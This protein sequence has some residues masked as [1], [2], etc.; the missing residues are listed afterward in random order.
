VSHTEQR[1]KMRALL[2]TEKCVPPASVHDPL[3]AALAE[4]VGFEIGLLSGS[5]VSATTLAAPDLC[6]QTITEYAD[7]IRRIMRTSN[8]CLLVDADNGY[9]N[10][11]NAM[12]MVQEFEH[13]GVTA[14][15]VEDSILPVAFG[16]PDAAERL[17][18][19]AEGVAKMR[20]ALAARRDPSTI[21]AAR[22]I[23]LKVE[24]IESVVARSKA[25]AEVGVDV[26]WMTSLDTLDQ[27]ERVRAVCG[28]PIILGTSHGP[29]NNEELARRGARI[30]LQGHMPLRAAVKAMREIYVEIFNGK[31]AAQLKSRV[32]SDEEMEKLIRESMFRNLQ[33][34]FM[35]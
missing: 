19:L 8:L 1:K 17:I 16:Q 20:A 5:Q 7:Q 4:S 3:S 14:I 24:G 6:L 32:A 29:F 13:A 15:G 2:A 34:E 18:P 25:Y 31:T 9:G 35:K 33:N 12:R 22:T 26:I 10:A 28:L 11:L 21:I 27:L 30:A 23:A